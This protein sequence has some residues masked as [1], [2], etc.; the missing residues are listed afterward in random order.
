MAK[1]VRSVLQ[2]TI[3]YALYVLFLRGVPCRHMTHAAILFLAFELLSALALTLL[4]QPIP[5]SMP[6]GHTV[7]AVLAIGTVWLLRARSNNSFKP[8]PLRGSA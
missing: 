7:A 5:W 2:W 4:G 6:V 3:F 8:K 1:A